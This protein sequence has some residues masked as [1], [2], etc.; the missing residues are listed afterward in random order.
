MDCEGIQYEWRVFRV[1]GLNWESCVK[2][3][4]DIW[5]H[6][7]SGNIVY[8]SDSVSCIARSSALIFNEQPVDI[9]RNLLIFLALWSE[10]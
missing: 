4:S 3:Q 8:D 6:L 1:V 7:I 2:D 5:A 9:I 10:R